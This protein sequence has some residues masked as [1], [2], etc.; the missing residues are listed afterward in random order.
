M[1]DLDINELFEDDDL[2]DCFDVKRRT[3][4]IDEG[5]GLA[6]R[7]E[8]LFK[9]VFG[10][11][12]SIEPTKNNRTPDSQMTDKVIEVC[13]PFRL[14][15]AS[16]GVQPDIIVWNGSEFTITTFKDHTRWGDGWVK[17]TA[18]SMNA[19]DAPPEMRPEDAY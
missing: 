17:V 7:E 3:E 4:R 2:G 12:V 8:E 13:T 16:E 1:P 18:Q 11:V 14:R 19:S 9:G 15:A 10:T 5:S 6:V